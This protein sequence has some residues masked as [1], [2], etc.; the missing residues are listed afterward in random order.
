MLRLKPV[1]LLSGLDCIWWRSSFS[2]RRIELIGLP[3]LRSVNRTK[4][5]SFLASAITWFHSRRL[6][7]VEQ[8]EGHTYLAR[9]ESTRRTS[10]ENTL[11][12]RKFSACQESHQTNKEHLKRFINIGRCC[13]EIWQNLVY[14]CTFTCVVCHIWFPNSGCCYSSI[15]VET[16]SFG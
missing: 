1:Y 12:V 9:K 13:A 11:Y 16:W 10:C 5:T 2:L 15:C 14:K 3:L 8:T 6:L 4:R 7:P